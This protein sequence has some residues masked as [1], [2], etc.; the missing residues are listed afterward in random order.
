MKR[1]NSVILLLTM[2]AFTFF[3]FDCQRWWL[4]TGCSLLNHLTFNFVHANVFH[5]AC[6]AYCMLLMLW[7][8]NIKWWWWLT[9]LAIVLGVSF[10]LPCNTI[11]AGFSGV[12]FAVIGM[13]LAE[14]KLTW[15]RCVPVIV[16]LAVSVLLARNLAAG[17]HIMSCIV[18]FVTMLVIKGYGELIEDSRRLDDSLR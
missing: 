2:I 7:S 14:G 4:V 17:I 13:T 12:L 11:T 5:L 1:S 15:K 6:N 18:G 16:S 9:A 3:G 8:D 10:I